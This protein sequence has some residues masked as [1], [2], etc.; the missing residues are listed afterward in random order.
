MRKPRHNDTTRR[1]FLKGTLSAAAL[2]GCL[3]SSARI[4]SGKAIDMSTQPVPR[5]VP[6]S[7][8]GA[9]LAARIKAISNIFEV[10]GPQADYRYVENLDDGRGY[11]VTS[12]GFCTGTGE[13]GEL[14]SRYATHAP[15]TPLKH[16]AALMPPVSDTED[17][18]AGFPAAW[19]K[20]I[21]NQALAAV[22]DAE[23]DRLLYA[24]AM[25]A[26]TAANVH[27]PVGLLVFYDTFLQHG[28]GDDPDSFSAIYADA[29]A[30]VRRSPS[31]GEADL[32]R[33]FLMIRKEVLLDPSEA[34]TRRVWRQSASRVDA[35]LNL[36]ATNPDLTPPVTVTSQDVHIIVG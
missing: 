31:Q 10:G 34:D 18:P 1:A 20:E 35:L 29:I 32:I 26:A 6:P 24:P 15:S 23:A 12:Y 4:A 19:Q 33:T 36:L 28:S 27:S 5:P 11:T 8:R 7:A 3:G 14:I 30:R 13:V 22:C 16:Y 25:R 17:A 9:S 21:T 2:L